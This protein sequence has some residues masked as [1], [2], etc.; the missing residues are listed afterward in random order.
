M[1]VL[2]E[3]SFSSV[4]NSWDNLKILWYLDFFTPQRE[5]TDRIEFE[6]LYQMIKIEYLEISA[7]QE[8]LSIKD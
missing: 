8:I 1:T 4:T 5:F 2:K 3:N 6:N 7:F